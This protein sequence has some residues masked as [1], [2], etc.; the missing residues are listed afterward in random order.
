MD[1]LLPSTDLGIKHEHEE[2]LTKQDL[3]RL[4]KVIDLVFPTKS[5]AAREVATKLLNSTIQNQ[6]LSVT[7]DDNITSVV[8]ELPILPDQTTESEQILSPLANLLNHTFP[9]SLVELVNKLNKMSINPA[10]LDFLSP[11]ANSPFNPTNNSSSTDPS[12]KPP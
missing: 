4:E 2:S 6:S 12:A 7:K 5:A 9:N 10:N 11:N 8:L 1:P 3:Q